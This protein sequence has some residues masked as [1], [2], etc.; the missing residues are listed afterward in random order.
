V[1]DV[2]PTKPGDLGV[3]RGHIARNNPQC[4]AILE[5]LTSA[6]SSS[7]SSSSSPSESDPNVLESEVLVIF[8][9]AH[10]YVTPKF[11]VETKPTTGK[12]VP[13]W[14]YSAVQVYGKVR[15]YHLS[16][17]P[18]TGEFLQKQVHDLS[19]LCEKGIMGYTGEDGRQSSWKV[20]DAPDKYVE[21]QKKGI[22]GLEITVDA[23][24]GKVKMSQELRKGDRE[25]VVEGFRKLDTD[26]GRAVAKTVEER[27]EIKEA[28]KE[29]QV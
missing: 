26:L 16:S 5:S 2:D 10:H 17:D 3:L 8:T 21:I 11:Y 1:L 29:Q 19:Q 22:V 15:V 4:K 13:T 14:N 27:S 24:E 18:A 28:Q 20:T 9:A 25:G 23:F 7:S 6:S 12:V